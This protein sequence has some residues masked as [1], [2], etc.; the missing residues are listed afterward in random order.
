MADTGP[1]SM[2]TRAPSGN[3]PSYLLPIA[4]ALAV[5]AI[6]AGDSLTPLDIPVAALY[7]VVVLMAARFLQPRAVMLVAAGC[8]G[9][10]LV[11]AYLSPPP[12]SGSFWVGTVNT[13]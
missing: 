2:T 9:L 7:V 11:E 4:T 10:T 12:A 13:L 3:A 5:A 8:A 1:A 6:F